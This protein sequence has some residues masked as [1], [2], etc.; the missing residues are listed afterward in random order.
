ME[1]LPF[2]WI[3]ETT[4]LKGT[5]QQSDSLVSYWH[6]FLSRQH[7]STMIQKRERG[8]RRLNW[9]GLFMRKQAQR[10]LQQFE[11]W[12]PAILWQLASK[13]AVLVKTPAYACMHVAHNL[14][15]RV[16]MVLKAAWIS[17]AEQVDTMGWACS[18]SNSAT[19]CRETHERDV[20]IYYKRSCWKKAGRI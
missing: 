15:M 8:R 16:T 9:R 4:G 13:H 5:A 6:D 14:W 7:P 18:W 3:K 10:A 2:S 12:Y 11:W 20:M 19:Y 17:A 1:K